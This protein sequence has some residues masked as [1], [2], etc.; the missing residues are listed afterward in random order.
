MGPETMS[1]FAMLGV[2]ILIFYFFMI[3]PE[4]KKKKA[5]ES[6]RSALK[7]GDE[8]TTIG[9]IVGE[10]VHIKDNTIVIETSADHVRMEITKWAI[11]TNDT[12]AKDAA[13]QRAALRDTKANSKKTKQ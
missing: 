12:A 4:S 3:R 10:V 5:L 1:T 7:N 6:M 9:G 2:M 8:I 11:G 13:K